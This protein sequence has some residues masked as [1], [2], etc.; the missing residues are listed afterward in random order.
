MEAKKYYG[1]GFTRTVHGMVIVKA[2]D[3][4]EARK[5]VEEGDIEDEFDNKSD[6]EYNEKDDKLVVEEMPNWK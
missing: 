6:C 4:E 1:V 3:E 2:K 5:M